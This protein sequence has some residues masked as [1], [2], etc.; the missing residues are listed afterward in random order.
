M[1]FSRQEYWS[2]LPFPSPGD[3]PDPGIEPGSPALQADSLPGWEATV[4]QDSESFSQYSPL[5]GTGLA[6]NR[7]LNSSHKPNAAPLLGDG[8]HLAQNPA[9]PLPHDHTHS[10]NNV[11]TPEST[12][13]EF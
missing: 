3:L 13:P 12:Q 1:G 9:W 7:V 8:V 5:L 10:C 2:G 6:L 11:P 4:T